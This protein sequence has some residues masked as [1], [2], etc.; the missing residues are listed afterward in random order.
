MRK[1]RAPIAGL[2]AGDQTLDAASAHYLMRVLRLRVGD[3]FVAFDPERAVD[4]DAEVVSASAGRAVVRVSEPR[5]VAPVHADLTWIHGMA[6]GDKLDAIVRDA[7][8]LGATRFVVAASERAVVKL[9]K[10]R[11][12]ARLARWQ[13]IA[14]EAAR[15]CGRADAP[16]VEGPLPW[17]E[18]IGS[19]SR[20]AA[21]FLLWEEARA[22][23]AAPLSLALST[24]SALAFAAGPEGGLTADEARSAEGR[25]WALVSLGPHVLRTET[26]AAAVLGAVRIFGG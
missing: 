3:S 14:S 18:A 13:R 4:A 9:A 24:G 23:L 8:E 16:R 2:A 5:A 6:K 20:A 22:P 1:V 25:G 11:G 17:D 7:T 19:V 10:E 15:Q 26:V 21:R 12:E